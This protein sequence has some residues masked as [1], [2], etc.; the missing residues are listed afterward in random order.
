MLYKHKSHAVNINGMILEISMK[1]SL[2]Q[3]AS[4]SAHY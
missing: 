1:R 4:I 2:L 3:G